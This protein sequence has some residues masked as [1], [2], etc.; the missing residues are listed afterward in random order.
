MNSVNPP[1]IAI[2]GQ[3]A[4]G[5]TSLAL[6]LAKKFNGAVISADSQQIYHQAKIGTNQPAGSWRRAN[7]K[8]QKATGKKRLYFVNTIPHFFIDT[9]SPN[10]QYSAAQFQAETN[11]LCRKLSTAGVL[12]I[13]A[14]GTGLY[15][16]AIVEGFKFPQGKPNLRLRKS[17]DK[18]STATLQ[19][20]LKSLDYAS[21]LVIDPSN[22]RRLIRALEHIITTGQSFSA[23]QQKKLRSNTL[24]IGLNPNKNALRKS[25]IKRTA[26]M[27]GL[28]LVKE[29]KLLQ[30]KYP[31]SPLLQSIGYRE[32]IDYLDGKISKAESGQQIINHTWQYARRQM[33][34]FKRMP[35]TNWVK[36]PTTAEKLVKQFIK[37]NI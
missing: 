6:R 17:L 21:W 25:I 1:I 34:W 37:N 5:K 35:N 8:W 18:L 30:K 14:G 13:I 29:V 15:V 26:K 19:K 9:L 27:F 33:T 7:T 16:S 28:G 22:R 2:V 10:K 12:P 4:S 20:K 32:I 36:K 3:T 11:K 31:H 23:N 24:I